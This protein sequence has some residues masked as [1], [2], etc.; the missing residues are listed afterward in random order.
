M[1]E[2]ADDRI[3]GEG[4]TFAHYLIGRPA[5]DYVTRKYAEAHAAAQLDVEADRFDEL[6]LRFASRG[7]AA[8]AI[9][10]PYARFA[11]PGGRL[12][13]RLVLLTAIME[14]AG[15]TYR[16]FEPPPPAPPVLVAARVALHGLWFLIRLALGA[17][18]LVPAHAVTSLWRR[19]ARRGP[20]ARTQ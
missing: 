7:R 4:R 10:D 11:R 3:V 17:H 8:V 6:L 18:V 14:C 19:T 12:R 20:V 15:P 5:P 16:E 9:A 2:A 1:A 13:R